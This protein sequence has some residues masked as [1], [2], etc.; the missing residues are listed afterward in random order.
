VIAA[1]A[2]AAGVESKPS[3]RSGDL[4]IVTVDVE[5]GAAVLFATPEGKSLLIDT[6]WPPG[7][8]GPRPAP[9]APSRP[10]LPS[11]ADRIAAAAASLGVTKIDYLIM[12][13]YH[14]DHVGGLQSLI[15]KIPVET[16][17]DHGPNREE[18]PPNANRGN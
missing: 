9:G 2:V 16:F 10:T 17:I 4:R 3:K 15:A 6:G 7:I 5:G 1:V 18:P 13:H 11:S 8:G 12:T 14:V